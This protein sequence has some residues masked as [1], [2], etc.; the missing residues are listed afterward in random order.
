MVAGQ[1]RRR[2]GMSELRRERLLPLPG[3]T[4][5]DRLPQ[6]VFGETPMRRAL[7]PALR[8]DFRQ[9]QRFRSMMERCGESVQVHRM[10]YDR[11]Y[12]FDRILWAHHSVD[13]NLRRLAAI[14]FEQYVGTRRAGSPDSPP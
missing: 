4:E 9:L 14:L 6:W 11:R 13:R 5:V 2:F 10:R 3:V 7:V 12:A 8:L 1:G